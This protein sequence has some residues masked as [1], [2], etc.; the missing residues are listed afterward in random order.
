MRR[1]LARLNNWVMSLVSDD[2]YYDWAD[3]RLDG[4]TDLPYH[5]WLRQ[6]NDI[7]EHARATERAKRRSN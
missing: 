4:L 6:R 5:E 3:Q 2:P 7:I 1:L